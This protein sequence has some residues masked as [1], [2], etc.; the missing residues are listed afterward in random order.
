MYVSKYGNLQTFRKW[1]KQIWKCMGK[2]NAHIHG[3]HSFS[4]PHSDNNLYIFLVQFLKWFDFSIFRALSVKLSFW[5][6]SNIK[7]WSIIYIYTNIHT[8][9]SEISNMILFCKNSI[10]HN[11]LMLFYTIYQLSIITVICSMVFDYTFFS[12]IDH[13]LDLFPVY[14]SAWSQPMKEDVTN[15]VHFLSLAENLVRISISIS[16]RY[17]IMYN[18][19]WAEVDIHWT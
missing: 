2:N 3:V 13:K 6:T 15:V 7:S 12:L 18:F 10:K 17:I 9:T 19:Q 14:G 8:Q 5:S 1:Q 4:H 11:I 16:Y